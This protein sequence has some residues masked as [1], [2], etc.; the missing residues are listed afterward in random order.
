M[1]TDVEQRAPAKAVDECQSDKGEDQIG[2]ADADRLKQR[3]LFAHAG[4]FE[5]PGCEIE[6]RIDA[7]ELVEKGDEE[8]EQNGNPQA[9]GPEPRAAAAFADGPLDAVCLSHDFRLGAAGAD[10]TK[11]FDSLLPIPGPADQPARAFRQADAK[12]RINQRGECLRAEH[13]APGILTANPGE[14]GI[15]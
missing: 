12:H 3:R 1:R 14:D 4:H 7:G 10:D 15:G 2:D 11:H 8:R 5:D 9:A 13:P 6:N